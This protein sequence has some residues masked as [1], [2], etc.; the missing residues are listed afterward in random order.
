MFDNDTR[1]INGRGAVRLEN[2]RICVFERNGVYQARI[3][4]QANR[5]IWRSLRTR[6]LIPA[7]S[8]ARKLFHSIEFRQQSGLPVGSRSVNRVIDE[9]VALRELHQTQGRT[10]IHMLRQIKRVV[11][12]WLELTADIRAARQPI[13]MA[14]VRLR[15]LMRWPQP[16]KRR[17]ARMQ[18]AFG[19]T[20][21]I[22]P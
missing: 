22:L 5:Y 17:N 11:K 14:V 13:V 15:V 3:R 6:N 18:S 10:S 8:A 4:T 9:Y 20:R 19:Q 12:F 1:S 21:Y 7:I 16:L 2:D